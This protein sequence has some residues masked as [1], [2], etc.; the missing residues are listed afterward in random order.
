MRINEIFHKP[1]DREIE[2]VIKADDRSNLI[3]EIDEYVVTKEIKSKLSDF[4]DSYLNEKT[5]NGVWIYGFFGSGKSHLLKM[6][7]MLLENWEHEGSTIFDSFSEKCR[8]DQILVAELKKVVKIPSGSILFNIDQKADLLSREKNDA[9]LAVFAKVF[10][11]HCGYFGKQGYIAKFERDI[12]K[13]GILEQFKVEYQKLSG[14]A[15]EFGREEAILESANISKAYSNVAK[16][17]SEVIT[18]VLDKYRRD[19]KLSIEDFAKQVRDYLDER[20]KDYRL[21]FFVDEVGQY[22]ADNTKLML[23]MQTIAESLAT[24]CERRAWIIVTSQEDLSSIVGEMTQ[25][26]GNDFSKILG[27]FKTQI[28]LTSAN[29]DEVIQRRLLQKSETAIDSLSELYH[30]HQNCFKTMF[31]FVDG[32]QTYRVFQDRDEFINCYPFIPYQFTL[33]QKAIKELSVNHAFHGRFRSVGER[34]MLGVFQQVV[35]GILSNDLGEIATFDKM[36][37]GLRASINGQIQSAIINAENHL[38]DE[39]AIKL[40]KILFMLKYVKDFRGTVANISILMMNSF[41]ADISAQRKQVQEALSKLETQTYIQRNGEMYEYLTNEEKDVETQIKN[42]PVDDMSMLDKL[43]EILF[44]SG[45][46]VK[47]LKIRYDDNKQDFQ[48]THRVDKKQFNKEYEIAIQV[49]TPYSEYYD[50]EDDK[51]IIAH[52]LGKPELTILMP[53]DKRF[54]DDLKIAIQTEKC[55][56]QNYNSLLKESAKNILRDKK[57]LNK[58]RLV[59]VKNRLAELICAAKLYMGG[60]QIAEDQDTNVTDA[61]QRIC[62]AFQLLIAKVYPYLKMLGGVSYSEQDIGRC[63]D[64][65]QIVADYS[66]ALSEAEQEVFSHINT[67]AREG[68]KS[69]VQDLI[70]KFSKKPY[71]WGFYAI[72]CQLAK[73]YTQA[74]IEVFGDATSLENGALEKAL[75]NSQKHSSLVIQ[76]LQEYTP[77][78]L[79]RL[80]EL[81]QTLFNKPAEETEAKALAKEVSARMQE[82]VQTLEALV[83]QKNSYPFLSNLE[84]V[85]VLLKKAVGK[86]HSWYYSEFLSSED[87]YIK[88]KLD[89][90]DPI[91]A[92]WSSGQK[93]IY[94]EI[95]GFI[96]DQEPNFSYLDSG[97]LK[98][99]LDGFA[100]PDIYRGNRI[101]Q[102]KVKYDILKDKL[103]RLITEERSKA[104]QIIEQCQTDLSKDPDYVDADSAVKDHAIGVFESV[105]A[106]IAETRIIAVI[107]DIINRFNDVDYPEI[108]RLIHNKKDE[109]IPDKPRLKVQIKSIQLSY[110]SDEISS[111]AELR[112]YMQAMNQALLRE[113]RKGNIIDIKKLR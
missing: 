47:S 51:Q 31:D 20:G 13:R 59:N 41:D 44:T 30:I 38:Q 19:Y 58:D 2:G 62:N 91:Q 63:L 113:I 106:R 74:R 64:N 4:V 25:S 43:D 73:L 5:S 65:S 27:R 80:K 54:W 109:S 12:D 37:D 99:L 34:S 95:S 102:L 90:I 71:G 10:D 24:I 7:S 94:D 14:K 83:V 104:S 98:E 84:P 93:S 42:T 81:S 77:S 66:L 29:V 40:L 87:E 39:F 56:A 72:L 21:N 96:R 78:Q 32:A 79:R 26:T 97:K 6:L 3:N 108:I 15:W 45:Q 17:S 70:D 55:Y 82:L 111:E 36:F 16:E 46:I 76:T 112:S 22:I 53:A 60:E 61:N 52:A 35:E 107:K 48:F 23:N 92:F 100:D 57:E 8:N 105:K 50:F 103:D 18:N 88:V 69:T 49:I 68:K 11:Y 33:F 89:L 110:P 1:V 86:H 9:L 75:K 67:Q 101:Q 28:N 85:I